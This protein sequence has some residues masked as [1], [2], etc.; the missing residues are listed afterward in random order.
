MEGKKGS[1]FNYD[2]YAIKNDQSK[3]FIETIN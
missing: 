1:K 3:L 2:E